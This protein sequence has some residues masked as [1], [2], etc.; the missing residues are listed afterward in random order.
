MI[1]HFKLGGCD[2][3]VLRGINSFFDGWILP[4]LFFIE[5]IFNRSNPFKQS[6]ILLSFPLLLTPSFIVIH[7]TSLCIKSIH[8]LY[9]LFKGKSIKFYVFQGFFMSFIV[10]DIVDIYHLCLRDKHSSL[11]GCFRYVCLGWIFYLHIKEIIF[12]GSFTKF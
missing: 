8:I 4:F 1:E 2:C 6:L 10:V 9:V 7:L 11:S 5:S 3:F 12:N